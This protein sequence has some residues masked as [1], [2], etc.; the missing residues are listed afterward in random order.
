MLTAL[1]ALT[2]S[3]LT[4]LF[5]QFLPTLRNNASIGHAIGKGSLQHARDLMQRSHDLGKI[6]ERLPNDP[7]VLQKALDVQFEYAYVS[8]EDTNYSYPEKLPIIKAL[9]KRGGRPTY[10]HL[11]KA[12]QQ[13]KLETVE[14]MLTL[15]IP[16]EKPG[17]PDT[18]LANVAYWGNVALLER[19]LRNGADVNLAS[20][21]GWTPLLAA[22]WSG[23]ADCVT[24][25]LAQGASVNSLYTVWDG[26]DQPVWQVIRDRAT[27][28]ASDNLRSVWSIVAVTV[29]GAANP[30]ILFNIQ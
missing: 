5:L 9:V 7:T 12:A 1:V 6:I 27:P 17:S 15:G 14:Y 23:Q 10:E 29:H 28:L 18:P 26:N 25:L 20:A 22:A 3:G 8:S 19:M 16:M 11:L 21:R 24:L 4:L 30:R 2:V 13:G